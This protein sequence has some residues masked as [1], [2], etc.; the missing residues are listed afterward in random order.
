MNLASPALRRQGKGS[1]RFLKSHWCL[2]HIEFL[3]NQQIMQQRISAKKFSSNR[4]SAATAVQMN[5]PARVKASR[6]KAKL[7][8]IFSHLGFYQKVPPQLNVGFPTSNNLVKKILYGILQW[9]AF[10]WIP[11]LVNVTAKVNHYQFIHCET[12]NHISLCHA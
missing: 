10:Y 9:P 7:P 8:S 3:R 4:P 6:Q 5:L 12:H 1:E 2:L 11:D